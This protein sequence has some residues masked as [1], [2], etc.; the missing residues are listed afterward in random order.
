MTKGEREQG[1]NSIIDA[2]DGRTY[3]IYHTRFQEN[4]EWQWH[5]VRVH[6]VFQNEDGWL[7]AAPFEYTGE[8]VTN[9]DIPAMQQVATDKIPGQYKLLIHCYKLGYTWGNQQTVTPVDITLHADGTI[10]GTYKGTWKVTDG[11]SYMTIQA[12]GVTYKGVMVNQLIEPNTGN[13]SITF[14]ANDET[15]TVAFTGLASSG[16]KSGE[17]AWAYRTGDDPTGIGATLNDNGEMKNEKWYDLQGRSVSAP[18]QKGVYVRDGKK[19]VVR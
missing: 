19:I 6:Q 2:E 5:A 10:S 8:E 15:R 3:L 13:N 11:T 9:A 4:P 12:G 7:V 16:E 14:S 1:H 17:T 18:M